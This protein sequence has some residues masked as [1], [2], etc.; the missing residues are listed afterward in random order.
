MEPEKDYYFRLYYN[1][2]YTDI[3]KINLSKDEIKCIGGDRDGGDN[4]NQEM[5]SVKQPYRSRGHGVTSDRNENPVITEKSDEN[6][7]TVSGKRLKDMS[8]TSDN[9]I[10]F[11]K[12]GIEIKIPGDFVEE[13]NIKEN[14]A[15]TVTI[16]KKDDNKFSFSLDINDKK[17]KD[18]P[19]S[20]VYI[21]GKNSKEPEKLSIN[22]TGEYDLPPD[23]ITENKPSDNPKSSDKNLTSAD[24]I[25]TAEQE[26]TVTLIPVISI[27][28][29]CSLFITILIILL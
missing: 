26:N 21:H 14:D 3:I 19:P 10:T 25:I 29:F 4:I 1:N 16:D 18:I 5:P 23:N 24:D 17:I 2:E 6:S 15:V 8:K 13:N 9:K 7:T 22:S 27:I 20:E 11:E 12:D 28:I